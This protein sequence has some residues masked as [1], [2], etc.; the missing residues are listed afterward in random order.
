MQ[1]AVTAIRHGTTVDNAGFAL[2]PNGERHMRPLDVLQ[3]IY[4]A[5]FIEENV[6]IADAI[7][8]SLDELRYTYPNEIVPEDE[9][10]LT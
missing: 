1:D 4:P 9:K 6:R 2:Y 7:N 10:P 8:F 5:D 3:H